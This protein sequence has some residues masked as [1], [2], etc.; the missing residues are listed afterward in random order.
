ML[1]NSFFFYIQSFYLNGSEG[2]FAIASNFNHA[3]YTQ[4]NVQYR[5]DGK[6][7]VMTFT[8]IR[9]IPKGEEILISYANNRQHIYSNF[10]FVCHCGGC[11][12]QE[13]EFMEE[14]KF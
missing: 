2:I 5:W 3:C 14:A 4:R 11:E 9:D 1:K 7:K 6:R 13:W 8:A 12:D 10:G